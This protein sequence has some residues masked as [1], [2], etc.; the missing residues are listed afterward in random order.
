MVSGADPLRLDHDAVEL[1][2]LAVGLDLQGALLADG[3]IEVQVGVFA[4]RV[5]AELEQL[6]QS[7]AGL[8][9]YENQHV[10]PERRAEDT[11]TMILGELLG[12]AGSRVRLRP[13]SKGGPSVPIPKFAS[14][15]STFGY[16]LR[17]AEGH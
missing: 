3:A 6:A 5:D 16:E 1:A 17:K 7:F 11:D 13:Q 9:P 8:E 2:L 10:L 14:S 12:H 15:C 4:I